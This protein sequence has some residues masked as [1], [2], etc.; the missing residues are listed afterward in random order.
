MLNNMRITLGG[1]CLSISNLK[2]LPYS[3]L[4]KA[5]DEKVH[6]YLDR[7]DFIGVLP[8][9]SFEVT[10]VFIVGIMVG[11]R[12]RVFCDVINRSGAS[13]HFG[14]NC[15]SLYAAG[16][17][18]S[19]A[20]AKPEVVLRIFNL[21]RS[22]DMMETMRDRFFVSYKYAIVRFDVVL[23]VFEFINKSFETLQR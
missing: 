8:V 14:C 22:R 23:P 3:T 2:S 20:L 13:W 5:F 9:S 17:L 11:L 7:L 15:Y 4:L 1:I 18:S 21:F 6:V 12:L 19:Q 10:T 16:V